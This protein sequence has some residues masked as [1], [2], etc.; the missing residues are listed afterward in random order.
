MTVNEL[1]EELEQAKF[2]GMGERDVVIPSCTGGSYSVTTVE[3]EEN[4][5]L[6]ML[7]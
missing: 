6:V 3:A 7:S 1:I 5:F 4:D 2:N